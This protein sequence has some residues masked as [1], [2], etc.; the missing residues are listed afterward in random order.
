MMTDDSLIKLGAA[1]AIG[2]GSLGPALAIGY[3]TGL[4][5]TAT[6]KNP[7]AEHAIRNTMILGGGLAEALAIYGFVI[8]LILALVI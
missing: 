8:A 3:I 2:L 7:G 1:I 5:L 6:G 4:A